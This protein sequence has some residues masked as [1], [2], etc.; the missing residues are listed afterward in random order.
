MLSRVHP[1]IYHEDWTK[2]LRFVIDAY[3]YSLSRLGSFAGHVHIFHLSRG[4]GSQRLVEVDPL[5]R[6]QVSH[7]QATRCCQLVD[8]G[9]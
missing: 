8:F 1:L 4:L 6:Q 9:V 5:P 7:P 2:F 3:G